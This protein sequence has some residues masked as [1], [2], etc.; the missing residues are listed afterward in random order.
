MPLPNTLRFR[1]IFHEKLLR[2]EITKIF[3]ENFLKQYTVNSIQGLIQLLS[4]ANGLVMDREPSGIYFEAREIAKKLAENGVANQ[5]L[6]DFYEVISSIFSD[7]FES[8]CSQT[9]SSD[10][11][12]KAVIRTRAS[13]RK[14][15]SIR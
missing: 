13:G 6:S 8:P 4:E 1:Q 9:Q 7:S 3:G 10:T 5:L 15:G 11:N 12:K 2:S 14:I